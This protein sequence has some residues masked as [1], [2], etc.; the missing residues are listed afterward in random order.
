MKKPKV[1]CIALIC[2]FYICG[3]GGSSDTEI[4]KQMEELQKQNEELSN[5]LDEMQNTTIIPEPTTTSTSTSTPLLS[6]DKSTY[7]YD[8]TYEM[9]ARYPDKYIDGP[10]KF[11]G[12]VIQVLQEGSMYEGYITIRMSVNDDLNENLLVVYE[13]DIVEGNILVDDY[14]TIYA[15]FVGLYSYETVMGSVITVPLVCAVMMDVH[16]DENINEIPEPTA[17]P[18][19]TEDFTNREWISV[20]GGWEFTIDSVEVHE[21]CNEFSDKNDSAQCIIV[22][23]S[24]KNIGFYGY[25]G[26]D[27][28]YISD[29]NISVYDEEGVK[30]NTYPCTH[31]KSPANIISGT[32]CSKA[33]AS[34]A[35]ENASDEI[36]LVVE[37]YRY[38]ISK[39][40]KQK[41]IISVEKNENKPTA[42]PEPTATPKP[43]E[44]PKPIVTPKIIVEQDTYTISKNTV[45]NVT[46]EGTTGSVIAKSNDGKIVSCKW[47]NNEEGKQLL[48][49]PKYS[50]ETQIRIYMKDDESVEKYINIKTVDAQL[51]EKEEEEERT[52]IVASCVI[53]KIFNSAKFPST[54]CIKKLYHAKVLQ[55]NGNIKKVYL[56]EAYG[57]NNFG[58]KTLIYGNGHVT[59]SDSLDY[60]K[61]Y[62]NT[63]HTNASNESLWS[64]YYYD[65]TEVNF[66]EKKLKDMYFSLFGDEYKLVFD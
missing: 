24:Y 50:G 26:E 59:G 21:L 22:T 11:T 60:L 28:L 44:T 25:K 64:K 35:L 46:F 23:Y 56:V 36:A 20:D 18:I 40:E 51:S 47:L 17:T 48:L 61:V 12:K 7:N 58:G 13:K 45:I 8:V 15:G 5:R 30:A 9:L 49:I 62:Y 37:I 33:Q 19:S 34:Y 32:K 63:V 38:D 42:T 10:V 27:R 14:I 16:D 53:N 6:R 57:E 1:L 4:K 43:T 52:L 55:A 65:I 31:T 3:C 39:Y 29:M 66:S 41:F 54:V 2:L